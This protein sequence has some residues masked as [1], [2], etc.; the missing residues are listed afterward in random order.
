[1]VWRFEVA[2]IAVKTALEN[3]LEQAR[4][5]P[6]QERIAFDRL[7]VS[8]G[9]V[10]V[11]KV[12]LPLAFRIIR[13]TVR[14]DL[15]REIVDAGAL[16]FS[17]PGVL[18]IEQRGRGNGGVGFH[19]NFFGSLIQFSDEVSVLADD[20]EMVVII[21]SIKSQIEATGTRV[22]KEIGILIALVG[23]TRYE[24]LL[25][26]KVNAVSRRGKHNVAAGCVVTASDREVENV[27]LFGVGLGQD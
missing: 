1:V 24:D 15:S 26:C 17:I 5:L 4:T 11:E 13:V 3:V 19:K 7:E 10:A 14:I 22:A 6:A 20:F 16:A 23:Y 2:V 9:A 8:V 18:H 27:F 12:H 25:F 21:P